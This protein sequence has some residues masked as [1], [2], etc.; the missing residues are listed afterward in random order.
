MTR[1]GSGP[2]PSRLVD[3]LS[4][5][6]D[7]S[8]W[9]LLKSVRERTISI[10]G[11]LGTWGNSALVH[12]SVARGDV[13]EKSDIDILIP[14][15]VSTQL[16]EAQLASSGISPYS[17]EITQATPNTRRRRTYSWTPNGLRPSPFRCQSSA[18]S[19]SNSTSSEGQPTWRT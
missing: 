2:K 19:N 9:R 4:V 8:H 7:A 18:D 1:R 17:R 3:S 15:G 13:D 16:V 11:V 5:T 14:T 12:G 6:Y 10:F